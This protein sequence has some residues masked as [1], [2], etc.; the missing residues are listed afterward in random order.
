MEPR[1]IPDDGSPT[2]GAD[3]GRAVGAPDPDFTSTP[4]QEAASTS[5]IVEATPRSVAELD[6]SLLEL[7]RLLGG[8]T[9]DRIDVIEDR[10]DHIDRQISDDEL[11]VGRLVPIFDLLM[12]RMVRDHRD[13]L[14][15]SLYPVIGALINRAVSEAIANLARKIDAQAR[16]ATNIRRIGWR[17][18]AR[19]GGA[20]AP[21]MAL[22]ESLPFEVQEVLLLHRDSGLLVR[23][24][25]RD[26]EEAEDRDLLAGMLTAIRGV[27]EDA[28]ARGEREENELDEVQVGDRRLLLEAEAGAVLAVVV[29]GIEPPDFREVMRRALAEILST[30]GAK[31]G[32][33]DGDVSAFA[34]V[35]AVLRPLL[36]MEPAVDG[37]S[38]GGRGETTALAAA[39][40]VIAALACSS[41]WAAR[42]T[43]LAL[44]PDRAPTPTSTAT[45]SAT[46]SALW[47]P[48]PT[49]TAR[50]ATATPRPTPTARRAT[51]TPRPTPEPKEERLGGNV[52][53]RERPDGDAGR[54]GVV[55]RGER[56]ILLA[57]SGP[58]SQEAGAAAWLMIRRLD[59]QE[60]GTD[61]VEGW[62][63]RF[64]VDVTDEE[65]LELPVLAAPTPGG[66]D[67]DG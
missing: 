34:G 30:H 51:A 7:R 25:A 14:V 35:S 36:A 21:E 58:A 43:A 1:T 50:R 19:L 17:L 33:F 10:V 37:P 39:A 44:W 62:I 11:L 8:P 6:A 56:I 60:E 52:W 13:L 65:V 26:P 20:D 42:A 40:L 16:Q 18:R 5:N 2:R 29:D 54:V 27:A 49:P 46:A 24:E 3:Q 64:M 63:V 38:D 32:D 45:T 28:F 31:L 66:L 57:R 55:R 15:E 48:E 23:H 4:S 12:R 22:R 41:F 59:A 61:V 47:T 9:E 67:V 53:L